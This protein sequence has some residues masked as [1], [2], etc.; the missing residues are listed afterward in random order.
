MMCDGSCNAQNGL[1]GPGLHPP[2]G[3]QNILSCFRVVALEPIRFASILLQ[4]HVIVNIHRYGEEST[5][6]PYDLCKCLLLFR[7]EAIEEWTSFNSFFTDAHPH[8]QWK[9]PT[10]EDLFESLSENVSECTT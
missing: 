1:K 7:K 8:L 5:L 6:F 10:N 4:I 9:H 2:W 3:K